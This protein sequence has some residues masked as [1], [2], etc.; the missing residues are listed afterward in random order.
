MHQNKFM[1]NSIR[2]WDEIKT[3]NKRAQTHIRL[4]NVLKPISKEFFFGDD[5]SYEIDGKPKTVNFNDFIESDL[6]EEQ[7]KDKDKIIWISPILACISQV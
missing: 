4:A 7:D 2:L 1:E 3:L 6:D 5:L